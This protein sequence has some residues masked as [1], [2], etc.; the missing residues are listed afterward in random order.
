MSAGIVRPGVMVDSHQ[1]AGHTHAS[2]LQQHRARLTRELIR[3]NV[4]VTPERNF[5]VG[6]I[7]DSRA[8]CALLSIRRTSHSLKC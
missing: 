7:P 6:L 1:P 8:L 3:S 2:E 5:I 4:C